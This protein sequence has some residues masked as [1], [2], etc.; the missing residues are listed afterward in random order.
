MTTSEEAVSLFKTRFDHDPDL[1]IRAPGRVN[2]IG[3]HTDY[4][5]GFALPIAIE[6]ST[7]LSLRA[8][9]DRT[10]RLA[11]VGHRDVEFHLDQLARGSGDWG[12]YVQGLAWAIGPSELSGWEGAFATDLPIG[13]GLSSSAALEMASALG[14]SS[15][16]EWEWDPTSAALAA[17]RAE[18]DWVGIGSG[19]MDQLVV[20][21]ASSGSA[22]FIDCRT[23]ELQ[24]I[25]LPSD[26]VIV[27]LDTGTR[28]ELLHSNY[29]N[30]R[31]ACE[32]AATAAKV[33]A[34]RDLTPDD[35]DGLERLVDESTFRRARHVFTENS[36]TVDAVASLQANDI[37][38]FGQLM[39]ESHASLRDDYEV[40]SDPLDAM[41]KIA[42]TTE[43][44][45][46]A[47]MTGGGF[48]G[49]AVAVVAKTA[50]TDFVDQV[51]HRYRAVT[52]LNP[53]VYL[54]TATGGVSVVEIPIHDT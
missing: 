46:G 18:N 1:L 6:Q 50:S 54:T 22:M 8:T 35:L 20:A 7:W 33:P 19:I 29:D 17:Q 3:E 9:N 32:R 45:I 44:C 43:G 31:N 40:S 21:S 5:E 15:V 25:P 4:T 49:C 48:G 14:F 24:A 27:I 51:T 34:L 38:R 28:R 12:D 52:N 36:R 23:L 41:V 10:V 13:A 11:S 37:D 2:L 30:R 47:R 16:S 42:S 26:I 53:S 39:G